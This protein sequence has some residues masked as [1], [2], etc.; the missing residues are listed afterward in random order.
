MIF[1]R[2]IFRRSDI[3]DKITALVVAQGITA[4][5]YA[6]DRGAGGQ[7]LRVAMLDAAIA[8]LWVDAG[9]EHTLLGD[10]VLR[11]ASGGSNDLA[12]HTDG[13]TTAAAVTDDEFRAM[14]LAYDRLDVADEPGMRTLAERLAD[15]DRYRVARSQLHDSASK[16]TTDEAMRRLH[17]AG[18][19]AVP[20]VRVAD[21]PHH[22]QV[23]VNDTFALGTHP[24]AGAMVQPRPPVQFGGERL[25][26]AG[27]APAMGQHTDEILA[28]L[29]E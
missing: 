22:P 8:S 23:L 25:E 17:A 29:G 2:K 24:V 11:S 13:W 18:V 4:A 1:W 12:P 15:P 6:R 21:V 14:C 5:L 3:C 10:G 16:L 26:P 20:L 28:E 27:P 9:T 7:H 19:P